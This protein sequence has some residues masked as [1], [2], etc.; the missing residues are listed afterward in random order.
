M[1][2]PTTWEDYLHLNEFSYNNDYHTSLKIS[3]FE[4]MYGR[5]CKVPLNYDHLEDKM[6]LELDTLKEI[7]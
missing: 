1:D 5:W 4:V 7:K 3:P 6:V 2:R